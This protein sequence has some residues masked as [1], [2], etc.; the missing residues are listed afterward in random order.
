MKIFARE[1]ESFNIKD[2][3]QRVRRLE[4]KLF[5][6]KDDFSSL[7]VLGRLRTDR[8]APTNSNDVNSLDL[9]YDIVI[10]AN[11]IYYLINDSGSLAWRTVTINSF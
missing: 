2:L 5:N 3:E 9:L 6:L 11:N 10:D 8:I 7:F 1:S 4:Q